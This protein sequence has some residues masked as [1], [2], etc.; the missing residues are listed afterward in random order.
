MIR[1]FVG[2][3]M[4]S[5]L[6]INIAGPLAVAIIFHNIIPSSWIVFWMTIHIIIFLSRYVLQRKIDSSIGGEIAVTNRLVAL[7]M[8]PIAFTGVH[9]GL[10]LMA[11]AYVLPDSYFFILSILLIGVTGGAIVTLGTLYRMYATFVIFT[12][13]PMITF[14]ALGDDGYMQV[15][16]LLLLFYTAVIMRLT[17]GYHTLL[18]RSVHLREEVQRLNRTLEER[19][20]HEVDK[21]RR[22]EQM[23]LHQT[24]L[25][26]MGEMISMIAHQWRQPLNAIS[27][28]ASKIELDA[29]IDKL[30]DESAIKAAQNISNYTTHLSNTIEDFRDFFRPDKQ[31]EETTFDVLVGSV[32]TIAGIAFENKNIVMDTQLQCRDPFTT[33]ANELR[34]VILNLLKNAEDILLERNV[35]EPTILIASFK[36]GDDFVLR[37]SDNG[38]GVPESV[39]EHI[40]DPY[41]ST[42]SAKGGTGLGLYMSKIIV[43][44]HCGGSLSVQ[45]DDHGAVFTIRLK[46][47]K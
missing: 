25:A 9:W 2:S 19:I 34:R 38:G 29:M 44:K 40:F 23:M 11:L 21:N 18:N 13:T 5:A 3:I 20:Q 14:L 7:Y 47:L 43:E 32:M 6:L 24:R 27:I 35:E 45:N 33:Y 31:K 16:S 12:M 41:F 37:I 15:A 42:K 8:I 17:Y 4:T 46:D 1:I 22:Q 26:Q 36:D 28:T 30:D 39:M 10:C